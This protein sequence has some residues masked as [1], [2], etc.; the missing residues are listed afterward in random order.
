MSNPNWKTYVA[1]VEV[2]FTCVEE[3]MVRDRIMGVPFGDHDMGFRIVGIKEGMIPPDLDETLLPEYRKHH[4]C[5]PVEFTPE[6]RAAQKTI[7]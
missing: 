4:G 3:S 6:Q 5:T 2:E 7:S 1:T